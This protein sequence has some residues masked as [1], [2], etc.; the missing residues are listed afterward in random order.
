VTV[1]T[2]EAGAAPQPTGRAGRNLGA[3]VAVSVILGGLV[4]VSLAFD[5]RG[6]VAVVVVAMVVAHLELSAAVGTAGIRVASVPV[7]AGSTAMLIGA[8]AEGAELLVALLA[9]TVLA[10]LVWRLFDG[11]GPGGYVRDISAS[12][13]TL[14][15][16]PFLACFALLMLREDDGVARILTFVLV[17]IA[18]DIGGYAVGVLFGRHPMAPSVSPKKSWEGFAGSVTFCVVVGMLSVR[19]LLDGQW[20]AGAVV[21]ACLVASATLG[22]LVESLVK[23]DL[24]IK[25]MGSLLPGHGGLMDRLDSLLPSAPIAWAVLALLVPVAA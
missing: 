14:L 25:D 19:Y 15:Y 6:F 4:V 20:W 11:T 3:A 1:T 18:S 7:V 23:R 10:A 12:L 21:G 2:P 22:D 5:K 17:T 24:G 13:F 9:V 16:A 8:Y